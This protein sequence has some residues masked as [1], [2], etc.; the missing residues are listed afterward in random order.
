MFTKR[1][2]AA[3]ALILMT[4]LFA[5]VARL[6][7]DDGARFQVAGHRKVRHGSYQARRR[8]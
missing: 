5:P 2:F 7:A 8:E 4:F 1:K 6:A 3:V